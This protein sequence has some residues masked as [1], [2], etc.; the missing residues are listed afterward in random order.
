MP[1]G[2]RISIDEIQTIFSILDSLTANRNYVPLKTIVETLKKNGITRN[3]ATILFICKKYAENNPDFIY[4]GGLVRKGTDLSQVRVLKRPKSFS[5]KMKRWEEMKKVLKE[6]GVL[7]IKEAVRI[8][9]YRLDT[10]K[11][12]FYILRRVDP[13]GY[14]VKVNWREGI[15]TYDPDA[16][17][18]EAHLR[19]N[20][21]MEELRNA[22]IDEFIEKIKNDEIMTYELAAILGV[23][24][25]DAALI[26]KKL[27]EGKDYRRTKL[28]K[29]IKEIKSMKALSTN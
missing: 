10:F 7:P 13:E 15:L 4:E 5:E 17:P 12:N 19:F 8:M 26:K 3:Q 2:T 1:R 29:L 22:D 23:S 14:K 21:V 27:S 28:G 9:D 6:R 16:E 18:D 11:S 20:K 24:S 25:L